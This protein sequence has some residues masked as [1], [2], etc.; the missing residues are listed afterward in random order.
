[1]CFELLNIAYT[2]CINIQMIEGKEKIH[3]LG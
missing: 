1:M 2:H 3:K